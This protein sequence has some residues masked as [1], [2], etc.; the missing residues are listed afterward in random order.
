MSDQMDLYD[1]YENPL[2]S[3]EEVL[4]SNDWSFSRMTE[5]EL[6]VHVSGRYCAYRIYFIW[7]ENFN[8]M[9]FCC[10]YDLTV[11]KD[12]LPIAANALMEINAA[13]WLGYFD[14]PRENHVPCFRHTTLLRGSSQLS[15]LDNIGEV[16]DI[17][18]AECER[19]YPV[20]HLLSQR[21]HFDDAKLSLAL[22]D[23]A[24]ES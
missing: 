15:G 7:Q 19:Y 24:G 14:L 22:M 1:S 6:M 8:A 21:V 5:D 16:V 20:F 2:D 9:Q 12:N 10:Q 18:L 13:L 23:I 3:V 4:S 17:A 11:S